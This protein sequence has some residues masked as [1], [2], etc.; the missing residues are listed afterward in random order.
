M[1]MEQRICEGYSNEQR[2]VFTKD[3]EQN[4]FKGIEIFQFPKKGVFSR[5]SSFEAAIDFPCV[6]QQ[7]NYEPLEC[8]TPVMLML[9]PAQAYI[10]DS[11]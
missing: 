3:R 1:P 8:E 11:S 9:G 2:S 4:M 6:V 10:K 5:S 7:H